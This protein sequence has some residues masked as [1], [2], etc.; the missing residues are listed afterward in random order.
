MKNYV[1]GCM[2]L[3][4]LTLLPAEQESKVAVS[5]A[6]SYVNTFRKL[7]VRLF[8]Q[9]LGVLFFLVKP[10]AALEKSDQTYLVAN[11]FRR[12]NCMRNAALWGLSLACTY[13]IG[14]YLQH[15]TLVPGLVI[16]TISILA[17]V[18]QAAARSRIAKSFSD[19]APLDLLQQVDLTIRKNSDYRIARVGIKYPSFETYDDQLDE[20]IIPLY[21]C[22]TSDIKGG[23]A[24]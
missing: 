4:T 8:K 12:V 23:T 1:I 2:L 17:L 13:C 6:C 11:I 16:G 14:A 3:C 21:R 10:L 19:S 9:N 18:F 15:Q 5:A 20:E 22:R 7:P 24:I